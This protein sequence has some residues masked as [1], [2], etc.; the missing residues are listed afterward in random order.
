M[1][2]IKA[3]R[4]AFRIVFVCTLGPV[5]LAI[6]R[7]GLRAILPNIFGMKLSQLPLPFVALLDDFESTHKLDI[8]F[9]SAVGLFFFISGIWDA[10]MQTVLYHNGTHD[11]DP[12]TNVQALREV[13]Q[14]GGTALLIADAVV[15]FIGVQNQTMWSAGVFAAIVIT[16]LYI[17]AMI[18]GAAVSAF[19]KH[20]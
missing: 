11:F 3:S 9:L 6:A 14:Y 5:Y 16:A 13:F 19:L 15:I 8:A 12:R 7:E 4:L 17:T 20:N 1:E 2:S 18:M 10:L